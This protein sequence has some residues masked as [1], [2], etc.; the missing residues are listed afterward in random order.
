MYGFSKDYDEHR[1][2]SNLLNGIVIT[3]IAV[4]VAIVIAVI[5]ILFNFATLFPNLSSSASSSQISSSFSKMFG[6][7]LPIFTLV[8]V[9]WIA[10]VVRAFNLLSDKSKVPLFRTGAKVLL[11]GALV[12]IVIAVIFAVVGFY[13]SLSLNNPLAL[14]TIGNLVQSV[15]WVFLAMAYFR[16]KP[17][18]P[19]ALS[20]HP[21]FQ[22]AAPAS[23]PAVSGQVKYCPYCGAPK[24]NRRHLLHKMRTKTLARNSYFSIFKRK[25]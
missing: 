18:A 19:Q 16:I 23:V 8:G 21:L 17:P 22:A 12:N 6:L 3:I 2:F 10:F 14:L 13:I 5:I 20:T 15:A 7:I 25:R 1:I 4:V 24:P 11:V 9:I